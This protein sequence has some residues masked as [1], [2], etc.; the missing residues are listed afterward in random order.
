MAVYEGKRGNPRVRVK[1]LIFI[2]HVNKVS[3]RG[4]LIAGLHY[5]DGWTLVVSLRKGKWPNKGIDTVVS[6]RNV[7]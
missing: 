1:C 2:G 4:L 3:Q 6:F 5:F 7:I